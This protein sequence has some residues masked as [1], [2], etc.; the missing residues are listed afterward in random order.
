M[1]RP[2][3][4]GSGGDDLRLALERVNLCDYVLPYLEQNSVQIRRGRFPAVWRG[5]KDDNC[6]IR[7]SKSKYQYVIDHVTNEFFGTW[8]WLT[9]V[10]KMSLRDAAQRVLRDAGMVSTPKNGKR[11]AKTY[12]RFA[13]KPVPNM[14]NDLRELV[15]A[16]QKVGGV[17]LGLD[18]VK[19]ET[20]QGFAA[21]VGGALYAY[22][23]ELESI[24]DGVT[25]E[26]CID[27]CEGVPLRLCACGKRWA[28]RMVLE[29][30]G[31][32]SVGFGCQPCGLMWTIPQLEEARAAR[33]GDAK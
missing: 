26:H 17:Q 14:P 21:W 25:L 5:G 19:L 30:Y 10:E 32:V 29:H 13:Q 33:V 11:R 31:V 3:T 20:L 1:T 27:A 8:R 15:G 16:W 7:T 9:K 4:G 28:T 6:S 23:I 2:S 18:G 12:F 22:K 24:A